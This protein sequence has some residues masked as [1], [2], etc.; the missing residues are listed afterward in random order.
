ME[1][2]NLCP[3][4]VLG[5]L[6]G[7]GSAVSDLV[8]QSFGDKAT[9]KQVEA[10]N[11]ALNSDKTEDFLLPFV[12]GE[13]DYL[14]FPETQK[15]SIAGSMQRVRAKVDAG[16]EFRKYFTEA[17]AADEA[18]S[19][20]GFF[21][22]AAETLTIAEKEDLSVGGLGIEYLRPNGSAIADAST[23]KDVDRVHVA[24][25]AKKLLSNGN[26]MIRI[27][28][29]LAGNT[30][31]MDAEVLATIATYESLDNNIAFT[32]DDWESLAALLGVNP[33]TLRNSD[34]LKKI[35]SFL[36]VD[37]HDVDEE[38]CKNFLQLQILKIMA[39]CF[40]KNREAIMHM[41]SLN[42][43]AGLD[44]C[45]G[46]DKWIEEILQQVEQQIGNLVTLD[47]V[48]RLDSGGD[49][50]AMSNEEVVKVGSRVPLTALTTHSQILSLHLEGKNLKTRLEAAGKVVAKI[51][52][53]LTARR[54]ALREAGEYVPD[55]FDKLIKLCTSG[56]LSWDQCNF[57]AL[58]HLHDPLTGE[59]LL[60][61]GEKSALLDFQT[62]PS[63]I[64]A[65]EI[66]QERF[67]LRRKDSEKK[68][69]FAAIL[70]G[71]KDGIEKSF[72]DF[73]VGIPRK[74]AEVIK[75]LIDDGIH[76]NAGIEKFKKT[77]NRYIKTREGHLND[78]ELKVI[79]EY[80]VL[81]RYM[82]ARKILNDRVF[83]LGKQ[84]FS[85]G[86]SEN[87]RMLVDAANVLKADATGKYVECYVLLK[88]NVSRVFARNVIDYLKSND[89]RADFK[90]SVEEG[91][92]VVT[93][94]IMR[95]LPGMREFSGMKLEECDACIEF[96]RASTGTR[97]VLSSG[98]SSKLW[99]ELNDDLVV[100]IASFF[101]H[102][103]EMDEGDAIVP[104]SL[105]EVV[106]ESEKLP[107]SLKYKLNGTDSHEVTIS[108]TIKGEC[109]VLASSREELLEFFS[110]IYGIEKGEVD[111]DTKNFIEGGCWII[112]CPTSGADGVSC[113]PSGILVDKSRDGS[114]IDLKGSDVEIGGE[115]FQFFNGGFWVCPQTTEIKNIFT[116]KY[117][118]FLDDWISASKS[119]EAGRPLVT[120]MR[121]VLKVF[122][123]T[124]EKE[125]LEGR[126]DL[127]FY[128]P[129]YLLKKGAKSTVNEEEQAKIE[130]EQ[131]KE[132]MKTFLDITAV[133]VARSCE[134]ERSR[135]I[136]H[137][138]DRAVIEEVMSRLE[139]LFSGR[140]SA[141]KMRKWIYERMSGNQEWC[142][143]FSIPATVREL[144]SSD[145]KV[146]R[147]LREAF[148]KKVEAMYRAAA[149][150]ILLE[151]L[152][153][154]KSLADALLGGTAKRNSYYRDALALFG[155]NSLPRGNQ[156]GDLTDPFSLI[157]Q[158]VAVTD[159]K[160]M[161]DL[162]KN[163]AGDFKA[164]KDGVRTSWETH[165]PE[166]K[167]KSE[168]LVLVT[169]EGDDS[170][171]KLCESLGFD[172]DKREGEHFRKQDLAARFNILSRSSF[173]ALTECVGNNPSRFK[174]IIMLDGSS[175]VVIIRKVEVP[176]DELFSIARIDK[177]SF[178]D[179]GA[180]KAMLKKLRSEIG[181]AF[182]I[183]GYCVSSQAGGEATIAAGGELNFETFT[184]IVS[185]RDLPSAM[186]ALAKG[187]L[188][189]IQVAL[190]AVLTDAGGQ[191]FDAEKFAEQAK[192]PML[193]LHSGLFFKSSTMADNGI[194]VAIREHFYYEAQNERLE[195]KNDEEIKNE[196]NSDDHLKEVSKVADRRFHHM[197]FNAKMRIM[198][199]CRDQFNKE[200][201]VAGKTKDN[202]VKWGKKLLF[203]RRMILECNAW[204]DR[205]IAREYQVEN[206]K[207]ARSTLV[208]SL[209]E[210]EDEIALSTKG[211]ASD[212]KPFFVAFD[213]APR[214]R[215]GNLV[216]RLS[217]GQGAPICDTFGRD[218]EIRAE[219][220]R[221]FLMPGAQF[222]GDQ[223]SLCGFLSLLKTLNDRTIVWP[224]LQ[225]FLESPRFREDISAELKEL[226]TQREV[227]KARAVYDELLEVLLEAKN[228][229]RP[230]FDEMRYRLSTNDYAL[231]KALQDHC[232]QFEVR[233][234]EIR[235]AAIEKET[236]AS[237]P[238]MQTRDIRIVARKSEVTDLVVGDFSAWGRSLTVQYL[239]GDSSDRAVD[240]GG[241]LKADGEGHMAANIPI[242][243]ESALADLVNPEGPY[244]EM[245]SSLLRIVVQIQDSITEQGK[246]VNDDGALLERRYKLSEALNVRREID[247]RVEELTKARKE[248]RET[249]TKKTAERTA[250]QQQK[251]VLEKRIEDLETRKK[252]EEKEFIKKTKELTELCGKVAG[253]V[254]KGAEKPPPP[255]VPTLNEGD[256]T[257]CAT[258]KAD[259]GKIDQLSMIGNATKCLGTM[260]AFLKKHKAATD[261]KIVA[262]REAQKGLQD[263]INGNPKHTIEKISKAASITAGEITVANGQK[264]AI[265]NKEGELATCIGSLEES[266]SVLDKDLE[267]CP[268][269]EG[270]ISLKN[271]N[272][273]IILRGKED[274]SNQKF[275]ELTE[276]IKETQARFSGLFS[277][278]TS[279][280]TKMPI[281]GAIEMFT[282]LSILGVGSLHTTLTQND[283][284]HNAFSPLMDSLVAASRGEEKPF[285]IVKSFTALLVRTGMLISSLNPIFAPSA[286]EFMVLRQRLNSDHMNLRNAEE[287]RKKGLAPI[288]SLYML[289]ARQ[290]IPDVGEVKPVTIMAA[291]SSSDFFKLLVNRVEGNDGN[292]LAQA[293]P[294]EQQLLHDFQNFTIADAAAVHDFFDNARKMA[295]KIAKLAG[296]TGISRFGQTEDTRSHFFLG[297]CTPFGMAG[298]NSTSTI[299]MVQ[300][301][302]PKVSE[303]RIREAQRYADGHP[304]PRGEGTANSGEAFPVYGEIPCQ[305][306]FS[307][308]GA[309][310]VAER[311]INPDLGCQ[312]KL[313]VT[314]KREYY[315]GTDV[316]KLPE[317]VRNSARW[318]E[319]CFRARVA[320]EGDAAHLGNHNKACVTYTNGNCLDI[321][322][323]IITGG[324]TADSDVVSAAFAAIA[325]FPEQYIDN[326]KQYQVDCREIRQTAYDSCDGINL[327]VDLL[328][329]VSNSRTQ[330]DAWKK[331]SKEGPDAASEELGKVCKTCTSDFNQIVCGSNG[332]RPLRIETNVGGKASIKVDK[333]HILPF[334]QMMYFVG[335][336]VA[337]AYA[338]CKGTIADNC[339]ITPLEP[340]SEDTEKA[341]ETI[342]DLLAAVDAQTIHMPADISIFS[343][344]MDPIWKAKMFL[345]EQAFRIDPKV[346][347]DPMFSSSV[348]LTMALM[349]RSIGTSSAN[350]D[351]FHKRT[352]DQFTNDFVTA[353]FD[354]SEDVKGKVFVTFIRLSEESI[355]KCE[356]DQEMLRKFTEAMNALERKYNVLDAVPF[357]CSGGY[358]FTEKAA[359]AQP[360]LIFDL[361]EWKSDFCIRKNSQKTY[362]D[363]DCLGFPWHTV[364]WA[365]EFFAVGISNK[366]VSVTVD[367]G[368]LTLCSG[369]FRGGKFAIREGTKGKVMVCKRSGPLDGYA[370]VV[371]EYDS[372]DIPTALR[373]ESRQYVIWNKPGAQEWLICTWEDPFTPVFSGK[374][375]GLHEAKLLA[376]DGTGKVT[377]NNEIQFASLSQVRLFWKMISNHNEKD[378]GDDTVILTNGENGYRAAEFPEIFI[379]GAPLKLV[380][381]PGEKPPQWLL[382][383]NPNLRL[384]SEEEVNDYLKSLSLAGLVQ[385]PFPHGS[386]VLFF[387]PKDPTS[388]SPMTFTVVCFDAEND[389]SR[390][391]PRFKRH[392]KQ[393]YYQ[394]FTAQWKPEFGQRKECW[395]LSSTD[396]AVQMIQSFSLFRVALCGDNFEVAK[397][398]LDS[399]QPAS[400]LLSK[401]SQEVKKL[402][403]LM[404]ELFDWAKYSQNPY[405][406]A[407]VLRACVL[408]IQLD[409]EAMQTII[410]SGFCDIWEKAISDKE[411]EAFGDVFST[412]DEMKLV[413]FFT[414]GRI[415]IEERDA[416]AF[417][418]RRKAILEEKGLIFDRSNDPGDRPA[419]QVLRN[420]EMHIP[421]TTEC[422]K[423]ILTEIRQ[424]SWPVSIVSR[425]VS[426]DAGEL[427]LPKALNP[428]LARMKSIEDDSS[429]SSLM[430]YCFRAAHE[431]IAVGYAKR[432]YDEESF[433]PEDNALFARADLLEAKHAFK[434]LK[435]SNEE[436]E[437]KV[438]SDFT[439]LITKCSG[440]PPQRLD[441]W[442]AQFVLSLRYM[443]HLEISYEGPLKTETPDGKVFTF[444]KG[445]YQQL[446]GMARAYLLLSMLQVRLE[447]MRVLEEEIATLQSSVAQQSGIGAEVLA[448]DGILA[449]TNAEMQASA[450]DRL[451]T[452]WMKRNK[453]LDEMHAIANED[454]KYGLGIVVEK[455]SGEC[456]GG[457]TPMELLAFSVLSG[458]WPRMEQAELLG[459]IFNNEVTAFQFGMGCGKTSLM[460]PIMLFSASCQDTVPVLLADSAQLASLAGTIGKDYQS[461]FGRPILRF[462]VS[463]LNLKNPEFLRD[464]LGKLN[465]AKEKNHAILMPTN[466]L[467]K[468]RNTLIEVL[469]ANGICAVKTAKARKILDEV[470]NDIGQACALGSLSEMKSIFAIN[471]LANI[472][473]P[474]ASDEE[475]ISTALINCESVAEF[476][477]ISPKLESGSS[478]NPEG[479]EAF[480]E[481]LYRAIQKKEK[482]LEY[483]LASETEAQKLA[484]GEVAKSLAEIQG[485]FRKNCK[486]FVDECDSQLNPNLEVNTPYGNKEPPKSTV[487]DSI[488]W[489][490]TIITKISEERK[491]SES[492]RSLF[493]LGENLQSTLTKE[494]IDGDMGALCERIVQ[495][496]WPVEN[497]KDSLAEWVIDRASKL[498]KPTVGTKEGK[499]AFKQQRRRFKTLADELRTGKSTAAKNE[500]LQL[501][502]ASVLDQK[503]DPKEDPILWFAKEF[504]KQVKTNADLKSDLGVGEEFAVVYGTLRDVF[505]NTLQKVYNRN[506]GFAI[507]EKLGS[508]GKPFQSLD[509]VPYIGAGIPSSN[510][511]ANQNVKLVTFMQMALNEQDALTLQEFNGGNKI[512]SMVMEKLATFIEAERI[513][514][515]CRVT[516]GNPILESSASNL[517]MQIFGKEKTASEIKAI[518]EQPNRVEYK[519]FLQQVRR[520]WASNPDARLQAYKLCANSMMATEN[521]R[522]VSSKANLHSM[523]DGN[524]VGF[525]GTDYNHSAWPGQLSNDENLSH[526]TGIEGRIF[527]KTILDADAGKVSVSNCAKCSVKGVMDAAF[528]GYT[529][530]KI[531]GKVDDFAILLDTGGSFHESPPRAVAEE[532]LVEIWRR[533][534]PAEGVIFSRRFPDRDAEEWVVLRPKVKVSKENCKNFAANVPQLEEVS[535]SDIKPETLRSLNLE[536]RQVLYFLDERHTRGTDPLLDPKAFAIST[537]DMNH[538]TA[539]GLAQSILRLRQFYQQQSVSIVA[540]TDKT[541]TPE[542]VVIAAYHNQQK[543]IKIQLRK[544]YE[545]QL[546]NVYQD[547]VMTAIMETTQYDSQEDMYA[548]ASQIM[549]IF[550]PLFI[551]E[552]G[553]DPYHDFVIEQVEES[554]DVI[555]KN[556]MG[557][558][559]A[560]FD[561]CFKVLV[562]ASKDNVSL[563]G[564]VSALRSSE[565][566]KEIRK[567]VTEITD[568]ADALL[569]GAIFLSNTSSDSNV[570]TQAEQDNQAELNVTQDVTM[571]VEAEVFIENQV[572]QL[573]LSDD[574]RAFCGPPRTENPINPFPREASSENPFGMTSFP[575][576]LRKQASVSFRK[577][578]RDQVLAL[579]SIISE[580][581][582]FSENAAWP[583]FWPDGNNKNPPV[584]HASLLNPGFFVMKKTADHKT[585]VAICTP[586]EKDAFV[587]F[588]S[589]HGTVAGDGEEFAVYSMEGQLLGEAKRP[590]GIGPLFSEAKSKN[591]VFK[592]L[593]RFGDFD[594]IQSKN[595]MHLLRKVIDKRASCSVKEAS[596]GKERADAVKRANEDVLMWFR[597]WATVRDPDSAEKE[598]L[599]ISKALLGS[600]CGEDLM[601]KVRP[602]TD[603]LSLTLDRAD[604]DVKVKQGIGAGNDP[605]GPGDSMDPAVGAALTDD[606][607]R[608]APKEFN[609]HNKFLG[610]KV[611]VGPDPQ[612][613]ASKIVG[614]LR[615]GKTTMKL[616]RCCSCLSIKRANEGSP[617]QTVHSKTVKTFER[618]LSVGRSVASVLLWSLI[619]LFTAG[620]GAIALYKK[621]KV[622][623][624]NNILL[625]PITAGGHVAWMEHY[626]SQKE[627]MP[628]ETRK[629]YDEEK[630]DLNSRTIIL[631]GIFEAMQE[632]SS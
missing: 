428:V 191:R 629:F 577:G 515:E 626:Y 264:Q 217:D 72:S 261:E 379:D 435:K 178:A 141:G 489:I 96:S 54:E 481:R 130:T 312:K 301:F 182:L 343:D 509:V 265:E 259:F 568:K 553:G 90:Q 403:N 542:D 93:R 564:A 474:S 104:H 370:L 50:D 331:V 26:L 424:F 231:F 65:H 362:L 171:G 473:N 113:F 33:N 363:D 598:S 207:E 25:G 450:R 480:R 274:D 195:G 511:I 332:F 17:C 506:Y 66:A 226:K 74:E 61:H 492:G 244:G 73:L 493:G 372:Y 269:M 393:P 75:K 39:Y 173:P 350:G 62:M 136:L 161:K 15:G 551:T 64:A 34:D 295:A 319:E 537:F 549:N 84:D 535:I 78:G 601:E 401:D 432:A 615:G 188:I 559:R 400:M 611:Q 540:I 286:R 153:D 469:N 392:I 528:D 560:T 147:S 360:K 21:E 281:K 105:G 46:L 322:S 194:L 544:S 526:D 174:E 299:M 333:N 102:F 455:I 86:T 154:N 368:E 344:E 364:R 430:R 527:A 189:G 235:N 179:A 101:E 222:L 501:F 525:T 77:I 89:I 534:R 375:E 338:K 374:G 224:L 290:A 220:R 205:H 520:Y 115:F 310:G 309:L 371:T 497:G 23:I 440:A 326:Q 237:V 514:N 230:V 591:A 388:M 16:T 203:Y 594:E 245:A 12:T 346:V 232:R 52:S 11:R 460:M 197:L 298:N 112:I 335:G 157:R 419:L 209:R 2:R 417:A 114:A 437:Q 221:F 252:K 51:K 227:N 569:K 156:G 583:G 7:G 211:L 53:K 111:V 255:A 488:F 467:L 68:C 150:E 98:G 120:S 125:D 496:K 308:F 351:P 398:F 300:N 448:R 271:K 294:S 127:P 166:G 613:M 137:P 134:T 289:A 148:K 262:M 471:N 522:I 249:H 10:A 386:P 561:R 287:K 470:N 172:F 19:P 254:G 567:K 574:M 160:K 185:W 454:E 177:S 218:L 458:M 40:C 247:S 547:A 530:D 215:T 586:Q 603:V 5:A 275:T 366:R 143:G 44:D 176:E 359:N 576:L 402:R 468:I 109:S 196:I 140:F 327:Y 236:R 164:K 397:S 347:N 122:S 380:E 486:G 108:R 552:D 355:A 595:C 590:G 253:A 239:N 118:S 348:L 377:S 357:D 59:S 180:R 340:K 31:D 67:L 597:L 200:K 446:V 323:R 498:Q 361:Q 505:P 584:M 292:L 70:E 199:E 225:S 328:Y 88:D 83:L 159:T 550:S 545:D 128:V 420:E 288:L 427:Q 558:H 35:T 316:G 56:D 42:R 183:E 257:L 329:V 596:S 193:R 58:V 30:E 622:Y 330:N 443:K 580:R 444:E 139:P 201:L 625:Q 599:R 45:A 531:K 212:V 585:K 376:C 620:F 610:G 404:K 606:E 475:N 97:V 459:K 483:I 22:R 572:V 263:W 353:F 532:T 242:S 609:A 81:Q 431:E 285:W 507:R 510:D 373:T 214:L 43:E 499:D 411:H 268:E 593:L 41:V 303:D 243:M 354:S 238:R 132:D 325:Q 579:N 485:F 521:G 216:V 602:K 500:F 441:S 233:Q 305:V 571:E 409:P 490:A 240:L 367:N 284:E 250:I 121:S 94:E 562:A 582:F 383:K 623:D 513:V 445:E 472:Q 142:M 452:A 38:K 123:D 324:R 76:N 297:D 453:T 416:R 529:D 307:L 352:F 47:A 163:A 273:G 219:I 457:V 570:E 418:E 608:I 578:N 546:L 421:K 503:S 365:N 604:P 208:N 91:F 99:D 302:G 495:Q 28:A 175:R 27:I 291:V 612:E 9:Y 293:V 563:K 32:G 320:S 439:R 369:K 502:V 385:L 494:E 151:N 630:L 378:I 198:A 152:L 516:N 627:Y 103:P 283:L 311:K 181:D 241:K 389:L 543:E 149:S 13:D 146:A 536:P 110:K 129:S 548:T 49:I 619:I 314:G 436:R 55:S 306:S 277:A 504:S 464:S 395:K 412:Q 48:Q 523:L 478:A 566:N 556:S 524:M 187:S 71:E 184:K 533:G 204:F 451:R 313:D 296:S 415:E 456:G 341:I 517:V 119:F 37:G 588:A 334:S 155:G 29:N 14:N 95:E 433:T 408:W 106:V 82:G 396:P 387:G 6:T 434:K 87:L 321:F 1:T 170:Y 422:E 124:L 272:D 100:G 18:K 168:K 63:S 339:H 405:F 279:I 614:L 169:G 304:P 538:T 20:H 541:T 518:I 192:R 246:L 592:I 260:D 223:G 384:Y 555:I 138:C 60:S 382:G 391:T 349:N 345:L 162:E 79:E 484:S 465:E 315:G 251:T 165:G 631:S 145:P 133:S 600:R 414:K 337:R 407:Y 336:A 24:I 210:V 565:T 8:G 248:L 581:L 442:A 616:L 92:L 607:T 85:A 462:N 267:G 476:D 466:D 278:F 487:T 587:K 131:A 80:I 258:L 438:A 229:N 280:F 276:K 116:E 429:E 618:A 477:L 126:T 358:R 213:E 519:Q 190:D 69:T 449:I 508:Q 266:I 57:S 621:R 381:R 202:G 342:M 557:K 228:E 135:Q 234:M 206:F 539:D 482:V 356:D 605:S 107:Y 394:G 624:P 554:G 463:R 589:E 413:E 186:D 461:F 270:L 423:E 573:T 426:G 512:I 282:K 425:K 256:V 117:A 617:S 144:K 317:Y 491:K 318:A 632:K 4:N 158:M 167:T 628:P 406:S 390:G 447:E 410:Q 399:L 479:S 3:V 36:P 575:V